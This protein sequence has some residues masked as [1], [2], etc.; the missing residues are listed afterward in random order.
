MI[1]LPGSWQGTHSDP[2][3]RLWIRDSVGQR[4]G[5]GLYATI[6]SSKASRP[7]ATELLVGKDGALMIEGFGVPRARFP[8]THCAWFSQ[9]P[10]KGRA[11]YALHFDH[12]M[13]N[14]FMP[15]NG[16]LWGGMRTRRSGIVESYGA[17]RELTKAVALA[18]SKRRPKIQKR[19]GS[20]T[21]RGKSGMVTNIFTL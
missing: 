7:F 6:R 14:G 17:C 4:V 5:E 19:T 2:K 15:G 16:L 20:E 21:S 10:V 3:P 13:G 1:P 18:P 9:V 11:G 8:M 12:S